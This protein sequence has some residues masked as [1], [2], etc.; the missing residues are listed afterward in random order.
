MES[1]RQAVHWVSVE[2]I[3]KSLRNQPPMAVRF[4]I[5]DTVLFSS[6]GFYWGKLEY[7]P[8]NN[9]YLFYLKHENLEKKC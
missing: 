7:S 5:D 6:P 9:S 3:E 4:D 8:N 2:K 1:H